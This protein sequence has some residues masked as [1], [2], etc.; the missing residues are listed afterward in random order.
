[1]K[2]SVIVPVYNEEKTIVTI[3]E[4]LSKVKDV[5]EV[6]IVSDGST[7]NSVKEIKKFKKS[8]KPILAK[9]F[10]LFEKENDGKGSAVRYGLEK[11]TGDYTM[12][13][14]A[15]LEYDPEDIPALL[16]PIKRGRAE[17]IYGSRFL[18]PHS[19][20]FFWHRVG[21]SFLNLAI[22]MLFDTTLSDME[23]C[24]KVLPTKLFRELDIK[25]NK[26]DMEPEITCKVLIRGI[27]IFEVP[28]SY[29]GRSF[30][31]GKKITWRDGF[32]ALWT[33]VRLKFL[34]FLQ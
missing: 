28:I 19:N 31:D 14:D 4:A 27:N 7:D 34:S 8:L 3:L 5:Y 2:L 11:V 25:A 20:L 1:M 26:F 30:E 32:S 9:K 17:V 15:D 23:T 29:V 22:N 33:I 16:A 24:Y 10:K 21:N 12:I 6:V 13:Q 18:G